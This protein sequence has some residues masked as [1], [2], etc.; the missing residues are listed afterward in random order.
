MCVLKCWVVRLI[1]SIMVQNQMDLLS[2]VDIH[3]ID[4]I[5]FRCH[6]STLCIYTHVCA[7]VCV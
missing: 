5:I 7:S 3:F 4:I 1:G 2:Q 6:P